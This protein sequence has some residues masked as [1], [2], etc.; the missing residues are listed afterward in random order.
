MST[1]NS[2][3]HVKDFNFHPKFER[4]LFG[5]KVALILFTVI[6]FIVEIVY[7]AVDGKNIPP[8]TQ[9]VFS[10]INNIL[11]YVIAFFIVV[12]SG[13]Y[14]YITRKSWLSIFPCHSPTTAPTT[15]TAATEATTATAATTATTAK[16]K[17]KTTKTDMF[18]KFYVSLSWWM[19]IYFMFL[20]FVITFSKI[21]GNTSLIYDMM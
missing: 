2:I 20:T 12:L 14:V 18:L 17:Q 21:T 10:I 8:S 4:Y 11:F 1:S 7:Y 5:F 13:I 9:K 15:A 3:L 19:I 16:E 6:F